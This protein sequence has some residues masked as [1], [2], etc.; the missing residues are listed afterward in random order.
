MHDADAASGALTELGT[1]V[2][3]GPCMIWLRSSTRMPVNGDSFMVPSSGLESLL[4]E[5]CAVRRNACLVM[6]RFSDD[7]DARSC[8]P[9]CSC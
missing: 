2:A 3:A 7:K 6:K 9:A 1:W 5:V 4:K 8:G